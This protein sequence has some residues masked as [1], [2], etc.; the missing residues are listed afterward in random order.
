MC[1]HFAYVGESASLRSLLIDPPHGLYRQAWAPRLQQHGT[2]NADGFGVG[3]YADGDPLPARYRRA[4]PM[5]G[6][7]SLLDVARVTRSAAVLA[8]VR[9]A[10]AGTA[11]GEAAAAPFTSGSWLFSHN[12]ALAGWPGSAGPLASALSARALP[13]PEVTLCSPGETLDPMALQPPVVKALLTLEAMVDSAF[14]WALVLGRLQAGDPAD[15][16]LAATISAVEA[17]GGTGRFNFLLTDGRSI[18][19]TTAG[20]T[21][22]YRRASGGVTVASEPGDEEPGWTEVPDRQL[23]TAVPDQVTVRPLNVLTEGIAIR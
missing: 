7:P 15:I 19:A 4:V 1:R 9:C 2:V 8:A 21:L 10:T 11:F 23:L 12:G 5:W 20:D 22:W 3:W 16:A 14:L 18:I 17:A 13:A 6:D